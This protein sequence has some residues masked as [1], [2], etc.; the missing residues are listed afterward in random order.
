MA[1]T[2]KF[3]SIGQRARVGTRKSTKGLPL[4]T[5]RAIF[6]VSSSWSFLKTC[7]ATVNH[8]WELAITPNFIVFLSNPPVKGGLADRE[9]PHKMIQWDLK[10]FWT[11]KNISSGLKADNWC[12]RQTYLEWCGESGLIIWTNEDFQTYRQK[13]RRERR[14]RISEENWSLSD[15]LGGLD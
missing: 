14:G 3:R 2:Q 8:N 9:R 4:Q 13:S 15:S 6:L 5:S 1:S 10:I 12:P 7:E 11:C